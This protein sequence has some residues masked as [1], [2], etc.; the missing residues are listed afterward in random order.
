MPRCEETIYCPCSGTVEKVLTEKNNHVYE[1]EKLFLIKAS[2]GNMVEIS[3]GISGHI[4]SLKVKDGQK[5]DVETAL[6]VIKDDLLITGS[7]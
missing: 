3:V 1:W 5:V 7:D 2:N 6:A 4:T